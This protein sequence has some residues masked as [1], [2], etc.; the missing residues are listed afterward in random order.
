MAGLAFPW[1]LK[2]GSYMR[3]GFVIAAAL[4]LAALLGVP[5]AEAQKGPLKV[6][7]LLPVT[8]VQAANGKDMVNGFQLFLD[9]QGGKLAGREVKSLSRTMN[10]S[11]PPVSPSFEA[12]WNPVYDRN[13]PPCKFC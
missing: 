5:P 10:Q 2:G 13:F 8:G 11:P 9:E 4:T 12:W 3:R 7:L 1:N 6:G